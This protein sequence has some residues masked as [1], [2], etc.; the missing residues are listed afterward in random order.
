LSHETGAAGRGDPAGL[1]RQRGKAALLRKD[2][3][4]HGLK[5]RSF[6]IPLIPFILG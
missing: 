6:G 4:C 2:K 1:F 5:C 3:Q